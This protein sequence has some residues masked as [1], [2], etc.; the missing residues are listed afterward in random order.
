[1]TKRAGK[2]YPRVIFASPGLTTAERSTF[3]EQF[4]ARSAVNRAIDSAAA[5]Q[6][7]VCGVHNGIDL[8]LSDVAADDLDLPSVIL[9]EAKHL[10]FNCS[11]ATKMDLRIL[12]SA[13]NDT[14]YSVTRRN[15][16]SLMAPAARFATILRSAACNETDRATDSAG[17]ARIP[18]YP[19]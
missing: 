3:G 6:R 8:E 19:V 15:S 7:R 10:G 2:R 18:S 12:R 5:E 17:P 13:Q 1:M 11:P 14:Q 16:Q 4:G 9:S